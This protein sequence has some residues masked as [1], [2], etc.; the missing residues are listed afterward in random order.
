VRLVLTSTVEPQFLGLLSDVSNL[1]H[2]SIRPAP[3]YI[4]HGSIGSSTALP[5]VQGL[6]GDLQLDMIV[7]KELNSTLLSVSAICDGGKNNRA[8]V[9]IFDSQGANVYL[10]ESVS[11]PLE[12]IASSAVPVMRFIRHENL[13]AIQHEVSAKV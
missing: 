5:S 1:L 7:M 8:H 10:S 3:R 2:G 4:V 13:Y 6:Y 9:C 12:H 11:I